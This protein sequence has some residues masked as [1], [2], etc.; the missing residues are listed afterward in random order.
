M[1]PPVLRIRTGNTYPIPFVV[2][3]GQRNAEF[4]KRDPSPLLAR[5]PRRL[6]RRVPP[7]ITWMAT[8]AFTVLPERDF[9]L[10]HLVNAVPL[11][12][13]RP[14]VLTF[15]S[16]MPRV[17][18]DRY[19]RWLHLWLRRL[20]LG[21]RGLALVAMSAYALRQF[22][23]QNR[24]FEAF[25]QLAAKTELVYPAVSLRRSQP[26]K[27]SD[28]LSLLFVG[29][30]FMHKGGPVV[31]RAHERLR[32]RRVPV[33][34]TVVSSLDWHARDFV[35]PP[36]A[37]YVRQ[38]TARLGGEGIVHAPQ[39]STRDVIALMHRADYLIAPTLHDTFGFAVLEALSCATPVI[40]TNTCAMPEIVEHGH[41][42]LLLPLDNEE[43][44]GK[45][46][47]L[48]RTADP[49]YLD[50]YDRTIQSLAEVL[51]DSLM[52]QWETRPAYE[53]MSADA[54]ERVRSRFSRTG[55]RDRLEQIYERARGR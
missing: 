16:F 53:A 36:S 28:S 9:D 51:T 15:E 34:T 46:R 8:H 22:A 38:E 30:Q 48:A 49:D 10:L 47:W 39:L 33:R 27:A 18:D 11:L 44:V 21:P 5:L 1:S 19:R 4:L 20:L 41:S 23:Y 45:W 13:P 2:D 26:K 52:A 29:R 35:G 42:G 40:A 12:C 7:A 55:A 43:H 50:A 3:L 6:A 17:P 31:V 25:P 32:Q 14:Y 37:A 54:I 24:G